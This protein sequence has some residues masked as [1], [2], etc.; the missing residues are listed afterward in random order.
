PAGHPSRSQRC[1]P[2]SAPGSRASWPSRT[3]PTSVAAPAVSVIKRATHSTAE[4]LN[5]S[6]QS[7]AQLHDRLADLQPV[8]FA[9]RDGRSDF[10]AV[11]VRAVG[12][13]EVL[14]EQLAVLA[15][16][17]RVELARIR[18]VEGDLAAR[19]PAHGELVG[20]V[21]GASARR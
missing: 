16:D 3:R 17:P 6:A 14:D 7:T 19:G 2:R 4:L 9:Y 10:L 18:V 8:A 13:A 15:E 12:R 11:E 20:Q 21:V 1:S 5:G